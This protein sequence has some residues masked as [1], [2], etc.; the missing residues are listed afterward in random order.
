MR[1][2]LLPTILAGVVSASGF[3]VDGNLVAAS[4]VLVSTIVLTLSVVKWV[5]D[6]IK[7]GIKTYSVTVKWQHKTILREI[8]NLRE[9]MGHSPL[10]VDD[11]L[12]NE[13]ADEETG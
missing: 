4:G 12:R 9:L 1:H 3:A 13:A 11:I 6:Q 5:K 7:D 8:S 10:D 2:I